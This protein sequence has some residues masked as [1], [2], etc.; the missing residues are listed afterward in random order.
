M[1]SARA[2]RKQQDFQRSSERAWQR[3]AGERDA[4]VMAGIDPLCARI[5]R[6]GDTERARA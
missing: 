1:S 4:L 6:D 2:A 5:R 3:C